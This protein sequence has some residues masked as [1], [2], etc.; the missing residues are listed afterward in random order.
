MRPARHAREAGIDDNAHAFDRDRSFGDRRRQHD[1][2]AA[3]R[4][5]RDRTILL[6]TGECAIERDNVDV[7]AEPSFELRRGAADFR[8]AGQKRQHRTRVRAHG[9]RDRIRHLRLDRARIAAEIARLHRKGA[10]FRSDRRRIAQKLRHARAVDGCRHDDEPQILAQA[11]LYIAGQRE[12]EIGIERALMEF[13]EQ[14]G[15][16]AF[17]HRIVENKP[18]EHAL[19]DDLDPRARR[20][21]RAEAH[22]QA[23]GLADLLAQR[24]GHA[25]G[26]GA[27]RQPPRFQHQDAPAFLRRSLI[28]RSL[29]PSFLCPG[30]LRQ[31]E[32]HARGL[33]GARRGHQHGGIAC[34]QSRRE[35]RQRG[36][37]RQRRGEGHG[38]LYRHS[39]PRT[40]V[41]GPGIHNP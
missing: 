41:R 9:P 3:R 12:P 1:L 14:D 8:R 32:W 39:G 37:D 10:P 21:F 23:Y 18:A 22:A 25:F 28:G 34:A 5:G 4:D 33:A 15:G 20:H 31:H 29:R 40:K 13:V 2:A 26:G 30:F 38:A 27:R 24:F 7:L 6:V 11:L 19:G 35:F 16:D 36:I 17:E